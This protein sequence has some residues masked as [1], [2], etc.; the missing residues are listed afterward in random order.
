MTPETLSL[1]PAPTTAGRVRATDPETSANAAKN[2]GSVDNLV[3]HIH[4]LNPRGLT[5]DEL[6]DALCEHTGR[7]HNPPTIKTARSR[8]KDRG[9]LID[10]G[11]KRPS[12]RGVPQ[13]VW[14]TAT[15]ADRVAS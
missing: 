5:D 14:R 15:Y 7:D 11:L 4:A 10:S 3:L 13:I 1:F 6:V 2:A 9:E 8:W 12:K